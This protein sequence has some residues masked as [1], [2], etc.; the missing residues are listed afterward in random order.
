MVQKIK[1]ILLGS[2]PFL[3]IGIV[4]WLCYFFNLMPQWL[5]PSPFETVLTFWQLTINGTLINLVWASAQNAAL[6]FLLAFIFSLVLGT[7]IGINTTI[8][9]I[10]FP[11]LSAI[12]PVPSLAWLPLA[13][14]FLGFTIK[15][16]LFVI[17]ISS[18]KKMIYS[19]I[20][21]VRGVNSNWILAAKN[22]GLNKLEI[23]LKV[24]LP[25]SLPQIMTG[26]RMGFG[27]AW[28]S[29]IGAEMLLVTIGGLGKFI[30]MSQW[31]LDFNKVFVGIFAIALVGIFME[32]FIL[33]QFEKLTLVK[34]GFLYEET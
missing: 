31:F 25:A 26:I 8:K 4:W 14:L 17:F 7:L 28:R 11:F 6:A 10:F 18:F 5:I 20:G 33:K 15:T 32:Q 34:W 2:I 19:I 9:K 13:V 22:L 30:W 1:N 3:L 16:V 21:G 24:I 29:L 27:S 23:V 12:Y